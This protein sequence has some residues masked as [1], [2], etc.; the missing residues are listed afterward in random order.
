M[1]DSMENHKTI[2]FD[3]FLAPFNKILLWVK[4]CVD[5]TLVVASYWLAYLIRFE[6]AVPPDDFAVFK[7]TIFIFV[8]CF[9]F[10]DYFFGLAKG[11][12]RY[13][14][15]R[16]I[17]RT[18]VLVLVSNGLSICVAFMLLHGAII[19]IPRSVYIVNLFILFLSLSGV[20]LSYRIIFDKVKR[21]SKTRENVLIVGDQDI[22]A[23]LQYTILKNDSHRFRVT[24]FITF[25]K[26]RVG[27]TINA[28]SIVGTI[29]DIP[30][31]V[32]EK[33][34][35]YIFI[36]VDNASNEEMKQIIK[37]S[38]ATGAL[39][40]IAP[41]MV[42]LVD[43]RFTLKSLREIKF[44]DYLDRKPVT[45]DTEK[46]R[47]VFYGKTIMVTGGGGS[48]GASICK[49]LLKFSP[50]K[51]VILDISETNLFRI[52]YDVTHQGDMPDP[53]DTEILCKIADIRNRRALDR[54]FT[55]HTV[56]YVIHAAALKHVSLC[57]YNPI[58]AI[59]T[60]VC[61][62]LNMMQCAQEFGV[63]KFGYISTDKAVN[64]TSLMGATKRTGELLVKIF[65]GNAETKT[66]FMAVRFGNV[67]GSSGNVIEIFAQQLQKGERLTI[68][69]PQMNRYF[70]SLAEATRLTLQAISSGEGGE[71]LV[72][73]MGNPVKIK[74]LAYDIALFYGKHLKEDDIVYIGKREGEK[75]SE[76]LFSNREKKITTTFNKI[77]KV[78]ESMKLEGILEQIRA[79]CDSGLRYDEEQAKKL[80]FAV[81]GS[82]G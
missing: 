70:M 59:V 69:D 8:V 6:G 3:N 26:N 22:A 82:K 17:E 21:L 2:S 57:E 55:A 31:L 49:E 14:S 62:T 44:E 36:A 41:S 37:I 76:E 7:K 68:T 48:I 43:G 75:T 63:K 71:I 47:D 24:G 16:D 45:F 20:R 54:I 38:Q 42:D 67:I 64:A 35:R 61:G 13:A 50:R 66:K 12:W 65:S 39:V 28:T 29:G 73:D 15:L 18:G 40:R 51:L 27:E 80:L 77:F 1:S 32:Q 33:G 19:E 53:E 79:V 11:I 25:H 23:S 10:C 34:I 74:D 58:E 5:V 4:Y 60:N 9:L 72:L 56:D 78:E 46:I 52:S 81:S 30:S